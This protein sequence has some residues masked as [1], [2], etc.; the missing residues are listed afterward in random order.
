MR[1]A[2]ILLSGGLDSTTCLAYAKHQGFECYALSFA[3]GQRHVFELEAAKRIA[4]HY[5][6]KK[7]LIFP[8]SVDVFQGSSLTDVSKVVPGYSGLVE[9]P[10]TYVPA[11]NTVFLSIALAWAEVLGAENIFIGASSIDYSHYPDCRP[12]FFEAFQ[13]LARL[14]TKEGVEEG[15]SFRIETPLLHLTKAQTIN[16]GRELGVD[17]SMTVSCYQLNER[18]EACASCDSCTLRKKGFLESGVT[19]P[20]HYVRK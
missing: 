8:L 13:A 9:I 18:G 11:R 7:H 1:K 20:T 6:V 17:Y 16:L 4:E 3:Y 14:A 12:A 15:L 2:I 5:A 19:D 10:V